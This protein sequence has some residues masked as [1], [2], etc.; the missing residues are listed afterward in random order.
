MDIGSRPAGSEAEREAALYLRDQLRGFGYEAE[1]Q[2]FSYEAS[3]DVGSSLD[4]LSPQPPSPA[5]YPFEPST[6]GVVE[7]QLVDAGIG[8]PEE[9]PADT[10]GK[11]ALIG[12]GVLFFSEKVANAE[13]VG[14]LGVIVYNDE[15]GLFAGNLDGPSAIPAL[16]IS[17]GDG[18][19]L[20]TMVQ[21]GPVSARLEV[22]MESGFRDSQNVV[23]RPQDGE[24]RLIVG[25]HYDSVPAGPGANDN[26]SGA[27]TVVEIARVLA[28]DGE[29]DDVC[30]LLFGA[31]ELGLIGSA[32]FVESLTPAEEQTLEAMLNFDMVGVGTQWLLSGSPGMTDLAAVEADERGLDYV[33][34]SSL[35][36][37]SDHASFSNA[38][39][40]AVFLHRFSVV[41]SDDPNY[42]TAEDR[43]EHVQPTRMAEVADLGLA[44]IDVLLG[45]R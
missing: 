15:P 25:G 34:E 5:V 41:V 18:R 9:F 16:T 24:C 8:R 28:A 4:V 43:A 26:A 42:H 29:F 37:G 11:I 33:V 32:R 40:P 21:A 27:A 31:E 30:F 14:A 1:F 39:I 13:A 2:P 17:Q 22:R 45:S 20:L 3:A 44:V 12:R 19:A 38:G 10:A 35:P 36:V 7:A 23:G 6:N